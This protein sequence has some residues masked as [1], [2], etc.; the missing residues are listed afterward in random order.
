V[1]VLYTFQE[2]DGTT[3]Q[4]VSG[5][6]TPLS[7][8]IGSAGAISWVPGGLVVD[9]ATTIL[10]AGPATK[11]INAVRSSNEISVEAWVKPA[12]TSQDG[13][14]RI[15][16]LSSGLYNRNLTL[17]QGLWG[18]Q[19]STVFDFRLRTTTTDN[20]GQPSLTTGAGTASTA[21]THV[22][23]TRD[24][25]GVARVYLN[26][27]GV[28]SGAVGGDLSNWDS[29]YRL[30]LA[31]EMTGDRPWV[32]EL[33]LVAIYG[34][35]LNA[36]E[37][38]QNYNAGPEGEGPPPTPTATNTAMPTATGTPTPT[39]PAPPGESELLVFDWNRPVTTGDHGFPR[40][41]PPL[42]SANGDWT[43]PV[44]YAEG[45]L[46]YRV[47][48]RSQPQAQQMRLQFCF[49]QYNYTLENCGPM[50]NVYGAGGVEV[51]WAVGV[52]DM[53]MKDGNPMDWKNPRQTNGVAIKNM[54]GLPV[55]DYNN[56]NWNGEDPSL[57]YPLDMRFTVVV[58]AKGSTFSGWDN[59]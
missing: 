24:V 1:Q 58:V 18:S 3:V 42:A 34:R 43:S 47:Q 54:A 55:S 26:G 13:P 36:G 31:N 27:E 59:Y 25:G 20:N 38:A 41:Y 51:T 39:L 52:Q 30:G 4:D 48:V 23:Y 8:I 14:A 40:D 21:L 53:W 37:V 50:A 56:W 16:T 19:P 10:S 2:G 7:L 6:G 12:N 9:S 5:V 11:V 22:V 35:A 33:D 45:T 46:Y 17:G 57:W 44:N 49:W 15:V 29:S 28:R 32:G